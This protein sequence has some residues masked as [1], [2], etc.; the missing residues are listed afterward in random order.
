[1]MHW[2]NPDRRLIWLD[3]IKNEGIVTDFEMHIKTAR[4]KEL[5]AMGSGI[6]IEYQGQS[7]ILSTQHDITERKQMEESFRKS[8]EQ[9]KL[10]F[11]NAVEAILVIQNTD[12]KICNPMTSIL[13]GY[14]QQELMKMKFSDFVYEKDKENTLRFFKDIV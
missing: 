7:C 12:I 13:T 3:K 14:S 4:G 6:I 10:L 1:M 11:E 2:V 5:W 8:E 9:Y